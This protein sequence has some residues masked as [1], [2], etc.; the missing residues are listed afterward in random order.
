VVD[1]LDEL[2]ET[3]KEAALASIGDFSASSPRGQIVVASRDISPFSLPAFTRLDMAEV[4]DASLVSLLRHIGREIRGASDLPPRLREMA[5]RPLWAGLLAT[6][7]LEV[8]SATDLIEALLRRHI[9]S[10][11]PN[12][13]IERTVLRSALRVAALVDQ[14]NPG[15]SIETNVGAMGTWL[16]LKSTQARLQTHPATWYLENMAKSGLVQIDGEQ[17]VFAHP[18]LSAY[19]AAEAYAKEDDVSHIGLSQD[20][21]N[22]AAVMLSESDADRLL[23]LL[24]SSDIFALASIARLVGPESRETSD[25]A[26]DLERFDVVF[27]CLASK[28]SRH[29]QVDA[30]EWRTTALRHGDSTALRRS[31]NLAPRTSDGDD[32][33]AW[34]SVNQEPVRYTVWVGQPFRRQ[35]PDF[36]AVSEIVWAFKTR[37]LDLQPEGSWFAPLSL[38]RGSSS[39]WG[40]NIDQD[41]IAFAKTVRDHRLRLLT[42]LNL[43]DH[44]L[45]HGRDGEPVITVFGDDENARYETAWGSSEPVVQRVPQREN[46][47]LGQSI[48]NIFSDAD[49]FA[50]HELSEELERALESPLD[51]QSNSLPTMFPGWAL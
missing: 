28:V 17:I 18:L 39:E 5:R 48:S 10:I 22:F 29:G 23:R 21:H 51:S 26:H 37:M 8:T 9:D 45:M 49:A 41:L 42:E 50:W 32:L 27:K 13:P 34:A 6:S 16:D 36:V 47:Y 2:S 4:S 40:R 11:L 31:T 46:A 38:G 25:L 7:S 12:A 35:R 19:L 1:G 30:T 44:P 33:A 20:A 43:L 15:S 24:E 3:T 14:A